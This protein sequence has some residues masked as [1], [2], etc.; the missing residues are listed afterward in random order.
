MVGARQTGICLHHFGRPK[1]TAWGMVMAQCGVRRNARRV[2]AIVDLSNLEVSFSRHLTEQSGQS[3]LIIMEITSVSGRRI[4]LDRYPHRSCMVQRS[5]FEISARLRCFCMQLACIMLYFR[6]TPVRQRYL[7][8]ANPSL[9]TLA[10]CRCCVDAWLH[11]LR[12]EM[13]G[14]MSETG[15][16]GGAVSALCVK[17]HG[18]RRAPP[19]VES[20]MRLMSQNNGSGV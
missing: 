2:S 11:H 14:S 13:W 8:H 20:F 3:L 19:P 5:R 18:A 12:L 7:T 1:Q 6:S 9:E 4:A 15:H 17:I 10:R 16:T